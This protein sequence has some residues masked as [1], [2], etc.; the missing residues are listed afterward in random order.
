M[1]PS[2]HG[3]Q[4]DGTQQLAHGSQ[5]VAHG[6]QPDEQLNGFSRDSLLFTRDLKQY[7]LPWAF[8]MPRCIF[9]SRLSPHPLEQ[10][11]VE[12]GSQ[13]TTG[14]QQGSQLTTLGRHDDELKQ[15]GRI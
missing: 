1:T 2:P 5:Q 14:A 3:S 6:S 7:I 12:Q 11:D 9:E 8:E 4:H 13:L 10:H 15:I